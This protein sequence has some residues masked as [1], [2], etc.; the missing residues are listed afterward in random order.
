MKIVVLDGYAANPG[1]LSWDGLEELGQCAIHDRTPDEKV[2]ERA[3]DADAVLT[4]KTVLDADNLA[5]L[6]KLKYIGVLATGVNVVDLEAAAK[7]GIVVTNVPAY[8]TNSVAQLVFAHTLELCHHLGAHSDGARSSKWASSPDFCYWDY[9]LI[10]LHGLTMGV[11]G[12][13][14]IGRRVVEIARAFGMKVVVSTRT[15]PATPQEGCRFVD[16]DA[17]FAEADVVSLNCPLTPETEGM[18]SAERIRKM[19][20]TA[21]LINTARGPLVDEQALADALNSGRIAGAGV[22][23]LSTEPPSHGNP[24]LKAKNCFVTP[25]FAWATEASRKRLMETA[26][27]NVKAFASGQPVNVVS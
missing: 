23:V 22:D 21:F 4:N 1:D 15:V 24:L 14:S 2:V 26:V 25:H 18:V 16:L 3:A 9:P 7:H 12:Y 27:A 17:L 11:V 20:K 19:K 5:K 8:S 10:E 6:D 13:G